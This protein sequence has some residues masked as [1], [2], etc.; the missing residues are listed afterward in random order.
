MKDYIY[1]DRLRIWDKG[2][3]VY[4]IGF[5]QGTSPADALSRAQ[6]ETR[7]IGGPEIFMIF[8]EITDEAAVKAAET[9]LKD[10]GST[11]DVRE[12]I[13]DIFVG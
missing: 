12:Q 5:C 9:W 1:A 4:D 11:V 13:A 6:N 7:E 10:N 2:E 8:G 3:M